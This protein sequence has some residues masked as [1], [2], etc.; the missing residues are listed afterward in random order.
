MTVLCIPYFADWHSEVL[1][2]TSKRKNPSI[3]ILVN[4]FLVPQ[5]I[6]IVPSSWHYA[7]I[8]YQVQYSWYRNATLLTQESLIMPEDIE[9]ISIQN[10]VL[11][12]RDVQEKDSGMYQC[13][14][15]NLHGRRMSTAQLRVL[16]KWP[17][18]PCTFCFPSQITRPLKNYNEYQG[19]IYFLLSWLWSV[20]AKKSCNLQICELLLLLND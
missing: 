18:P 12:I 1:I 10:N 16:C 20:M 8:F 3:P 5:H 14:G 4:I 11:T 13:A 15:T 19:D 17:S 2:L 7:Y 9:R 6:C